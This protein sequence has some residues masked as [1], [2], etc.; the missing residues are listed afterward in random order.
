M[1][2]QLS[3]IVASNSGV[4]VAVT[5]MLRSTIISSTSSD[6]HDAIAKAVATTAKAQKSFFVFIIVYYV[7][8][9]MRLKLQGGVMRII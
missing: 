6:W 4:V 2:P 8:S 5:L 3:S 9:T 1:L 7:N